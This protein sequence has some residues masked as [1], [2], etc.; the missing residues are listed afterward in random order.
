MSRTVATRWPAL[1][2]TQVHWVVMITLPIYLLILV[3]IG[4]LLKPYAVLDFRNLAQVALV[5]VVIASIFW[6][7]RRGMAFQLIPVGRG[8]SRAHW[9]LLDIISLCCINGL[10]WF[11]PFT[12]HCT[13]GVEGRPGPGVPR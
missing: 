6:L 4:A 1:H 2:V 3:A 7:I 8:F 13:R 9:I 5:L 12:T 11:V 10:A